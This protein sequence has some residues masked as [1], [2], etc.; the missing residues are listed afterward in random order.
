[1]LSISA[2]LVDTSL[3]AME[4]SV[5]PQYAVYT[6][7][8]EHKVVKANKEHPCYG[9]PARIKNFWLMA[10]SPLCKGIEYGSLHL[11]FNNPLTRLGSKSC[12]PCVLHY[13][14]SELHGELA[15]YRPLTEEQM[16]QARLDMEADV[17]E[18]LEA[19]PKN[20]LRLECCCGGPMTQDCFDNCQ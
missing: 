1:M 10:T 12:L 9:V 13:G 2:F 11:E 3:L 19:E 5:M 15:Q 6:L 7:T 8:S 4:E 17:T 16:Q 18:L 14:F 20:P